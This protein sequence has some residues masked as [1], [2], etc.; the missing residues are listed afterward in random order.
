[1]IHSEPLVKH[2]ETL[3]HKSFHATIPALDVKTSAFGAATSAI[4]WGHSMQRYRGSMRRCR[5][6]ARWYRHGVS[7]S[8]SY[9]G[10]GITMRMC[11][12]VTNHR[13]I[14]TFS[15]PVLY[16]YFF[17]RRCTNGLVKHFV[18]IFVNLVTCKVAKLIRQEFFFHISKRTMHNAGKNIPINFI[19][20]P[21][22]LMS[23]QILVKN[24][25][26]LHQ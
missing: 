25:S 22:K 5:R 24:C 8:I 10:V 15:K 20:L 26:S 11:N 12:R 3:K 13:D 14:S 17:Q 19:Y 6:S 9:C 4:A 1:M 23:L 21:A 7:G 2:H 18:K 16:G